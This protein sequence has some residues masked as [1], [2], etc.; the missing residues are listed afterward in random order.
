MRQQLFSLLHAEQT[1]LGLVEFILVAVGFNLIEAISKRCAV[2]CFDSTSHNEGKSVRR[3]Q[4][5]TS[6]LGP[7]EADA[8]QGDEQQIVSREGAEAEA[9]AEAR[10]AGRTRPSVGRQARVHLAVQIPS[11]RPTAGLGRSD[12]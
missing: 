5:A 2:K 1:R 4:S 11:R 6:V 3:Y 12:L 10:A 9:G 8:V 7:D